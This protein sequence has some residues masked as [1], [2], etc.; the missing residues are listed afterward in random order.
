MLL[1][2]LSLFQD[3]LISETSFT[4]DSTNSMSNA[5]PGITILIQYQIKDQNQNFLDFPKPKL[6]S[7]PF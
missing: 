6:L 2:T 7:L 3:E 5:K 4:M 1:S